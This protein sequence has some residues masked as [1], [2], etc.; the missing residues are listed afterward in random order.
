MGHFLLRRL[1]TSLVTI[2]AI[3]SIAFILFRLL[4]GDPASVMLSPLL[5]AEMRQAVR[6]SFGLDKPLLEQY[7]RYVANLFRLEFGK[8]FLQRRPVIDV[9]KDRLANTLI[10]AGAAFV[11]TYGLA[12]PLSLLM[13][14]KRGTWIE[15]TLVAICLILR[16]PPVFWSGM[17]AIMVFS[18]YLGWFPVNPHNSQV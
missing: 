4:P 16:A 10:L 17:L 6:T 1:A 15:S 14:A 5:S 3:I 2:I 18:F 12:I 7:L 9:I 8:S 11:L 13:T